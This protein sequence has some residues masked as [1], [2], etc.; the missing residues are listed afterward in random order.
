MTIN[1]C[2][3][4]IREAIKKLNQMKHALKFGF[5]ETDYGIFLTAYSSDGTRR[6]GAYEVLN[7]FEDFK[8]KTTAYKYFMESVELIVA[9]TRLNDPK[10]YHNL[11]AN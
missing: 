1:D 3:H 10:A 8:N 11:I 9:S 2:K 6:F 5:E 4:R 7:L